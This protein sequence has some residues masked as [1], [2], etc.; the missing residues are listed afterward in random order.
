[1]SRRMK[2]I[3]IKEVHTASPSQIEKYND[4]ISS[5]DSLST[6]QHKMEP[7]N[8]ATIRITNIVIA[9]VAIGIVS[10]GIL[11]L[12]PSPFSPAGLVG[13]TIDS[14]SVDF[15]FQLLNG[16]E[17]KLSNYKGQPLFLDLFAINCPPCKAQIKEFKSLIATYPYVQILSITVDNSDTIANLEDFGSETGI[18]W[19]IGRDNT[20]K[21]TE[22]FKVNNIP[23]IVFFN[24]NGVLKKIEIGLHYYATLASWVVEN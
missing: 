20:Y 4:E 11:S 3:P 1:M 8:Q 14:E 13:K 19:T 16:S 17:T 22:N 5:L 10:L 6:Q 7:N 24:S 12:E 18:T 21:G 2:K 23:T 15:S 9:I